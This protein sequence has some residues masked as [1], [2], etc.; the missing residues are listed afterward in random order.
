MA[1]SMFLIVG[2]TGVGKSSSLELLPNQNEWLYFNCDAGKEIP[3][4][5][6]FIE[7]KITDPKDIPATIE[8]VIANNR[9]I[10]G[11]IIDTVTF[12]MEMF[13]SKYVKTA[14]D[15]FAAWDAY[16]EFFRDLVQDK[17]NR[18]EGDVI[19]IAHI[20]KKYNKEAMV[21][22][23]VV[24]VSGSL[25]KVGL[26]AYFTNVIQA[27]VKTL[28][29]LSAYTNPMLNITEEEKIVGIKHVFQTMKTADSVNTRIRSPRRMWTINETFIDNDVLQVM[30]RQ[31]DFYK[32]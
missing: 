22:Q 15:T 10:K 3:F 9:P 20:D 1:K 6:N 30:M 16:G 32:K 27:S 12:M 7:V 5:H 21:E 4:P 2:E 17:L 31:H 29:D 14:S 11:I 24:P 26:E 13:K 18:F 19:L 23:T 25:A 8:D 28:T